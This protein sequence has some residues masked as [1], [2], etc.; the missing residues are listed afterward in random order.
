VLALVVIVAAIPAAIMDTIEM[1]RVYLFSRQLLEESP[2]RFTRPEHFRFILQS[3]FAVLLGVRGCL[4]DV[5][6]G[7]PP[8]LFGLLFDAEHRRALLRSGLNAIGTLHSARCWDN[9]GCRVSTLI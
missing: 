8:Y 1:G 3:T 6:A 9:P 4:A 7:N 5:K 2:Q